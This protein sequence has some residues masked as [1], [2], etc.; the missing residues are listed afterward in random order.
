MQHFIEDP[1]FA[2]LYLETV[3]ADGDAHE[4]AQVQAWCNEA[5]TQTQK[6]GYWGN[7]I[8]NAEKTAQEGM[9][10]EVII[11][12][13]TRALGILKADVPAGA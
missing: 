5:K 13:L 6:L 8:D 4:I 2:D 10:H 11:A 9:N 12:L 1:D 3:N 7:V